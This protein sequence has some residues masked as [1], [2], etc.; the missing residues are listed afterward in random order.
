MLRNHTPIDGA[1]HPDALPGNREEEHALFGDITDDGGEDDTEE[2]DDS[3]SDDYFDEDNST[4]EVLQNDV[5]LDVF[6]TN[7]LASLP[8]SVLRDY[9]ELGKVQNTVLRGECLLIS[10]YVHHLFITQPKNFRRIMK[11]SNWLTDTMIEKLQTISRD[12]GSRFGDNLK[13]RGHWEDIEFIRRSF[14]PHGG[15]HSSI[16][17]NKPTFKSVLNLKRRNCNEEPATFPTFV[18]KYDGHNKSKG[19]HHIIKLFSCGDVGIFSND[20]PCVLLLRNGHFYNVSLFLSM[21]N[22]KIGGKR[23]SGGASSQRYKKLFCLRC[24][25]SYSND[26][27]HVCEGHCFRCLSTTDEHLNDGNLTKEI[28]LHVETVV[29]RFCNSFVIEFTSNAN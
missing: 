28:K 4:C 9:Y 19:S 22:P 20:K 18:L 21:D 3:P 24:T 14:S 13:G 27:L 12:A 17:V 16:N 7:E 25:V 6:L 23:K 5:A 15:G 10:L 8:P 1:F 2:E 26:H 11:K 29:K